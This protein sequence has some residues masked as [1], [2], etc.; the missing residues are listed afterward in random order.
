MGVLSR[1][2]GRRV[3]GSTGTNFF[4][5]CLA[6][7]DEVTKGSLVSLICAG[8]ERYGH[9]YHNDDWIAAQGFD[10]TPHERA[11]DALLDR[12]TQAIVKGQARQRVPCR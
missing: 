6:L 12:E 5:L 10:L 7:Q 1:R 8:G 11:L 3:G 2:L 4:G 9:T